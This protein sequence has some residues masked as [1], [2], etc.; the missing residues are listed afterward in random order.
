MADTKDV[1]AEI[2]RDAI[3]FGP[4]VIKI[5]KSVKAL[6]GKSKTGHE[7]LAIAKEAIRDSEAVA[8]AIANKDLVDTDALDALVTEAA[9]LGYQAMKIEERL[10]AI[11][12][13]IKALKPKAA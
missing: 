2:T 6:F 13:A 10:E 7:K 1:L 8:E 11:K 12:S 9:E 4:T 5:A 3:K